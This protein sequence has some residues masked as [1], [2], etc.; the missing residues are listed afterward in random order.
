MTALELHDRLCDGDNCRGGAAAEQPGQG[1]TA[2]LSGG[3]DCAEGTP[4]PAS[5]TE[6]PW[7]PLRDMEPLEA[8][9]ADGN[10]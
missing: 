6:D 5:T 2:P 1:A 4:A 7:A 3:A 8:W 9:N 10:R